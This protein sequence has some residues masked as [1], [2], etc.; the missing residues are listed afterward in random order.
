MRLFWC[1]SDLT[2]IVMMHVLL[3]FLMIAHLNSHWFD[4]LAPN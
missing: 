1:Y 3:D 2:S 4:S